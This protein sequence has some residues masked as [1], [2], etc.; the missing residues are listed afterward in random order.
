MTR[1]GDRYSAKTL[2][3]RPLTP[4]LWPALE[5]LFGE[6]GACNG[7]WCMYWRIGADYRRKPRGRNKEAFREVVERGPPPG[8]LAFDGDVPVGWCQV[9][10][11]DGLPWLDRVWRLKRVDD[12]PVW[13][14]SCFYV[15]KGYRKRGITFALIEAA[16]DA[17]RRAKAP[18][19]EAYPLDADL[20]PSASGTGYAST[21]ARAGFETV[22]R[23]VL[24]RPIMRYTLRTSRRQTRARPSGD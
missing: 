24:S 4:D 12:R 13:S 18:A 2:A 6:Q 9:T 21:F 14:L 7:C 16:L 1:G 3:I 15:R 19:L 20:T 5:D 11:R 10:P 23:H 8:L 17:A 22:A